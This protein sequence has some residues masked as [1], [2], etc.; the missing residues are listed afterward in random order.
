MYAVDKS[1]L[2]NLSN[3][4]SQNPHKKKT[5][6]KLCVIPSDRCDCKEV[7][8]LIWFTEQV[9]SSSN[10]LGFYFGSVPLEFKLEHGLY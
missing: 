4:I 1:G 2:G 5:V 6:S 8:L 7:Y 3:C 9:A 10:S